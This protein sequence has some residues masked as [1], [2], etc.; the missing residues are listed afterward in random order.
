MDKKTKE[1]VGV[2]IGDAYGGKLRSEHGAKGLWNSLPAVYRGAGTLRLP[3]M[4][5]L[6]Y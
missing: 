1:I 6:L 2:H 5:C 4:F 3:S